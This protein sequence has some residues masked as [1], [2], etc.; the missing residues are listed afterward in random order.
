M[1]KEIFKS[2][3]RL[4]EYF[5]AEDGTPFYTE[6]AALNYSRANKLEKAPVKVER[7]QE[8]E[9]SGTTVVF[10]ESMSRA[11]LNQIAL[12]HG[13]EDAESL[14]NKKAVIEALELLFGDDLEDESFDDE[15]ANESGDDGDSDEVEEILP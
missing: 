3:P 6:N 8:N 4:K 12:D 11:E 2:N 9:L 7:E 1:G 10:N 14:P 13:I 15:N 5:E